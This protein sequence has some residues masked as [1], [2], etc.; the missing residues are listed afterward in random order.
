[1]ISFVIRQARPEDRARIT[2]LLD[3]ASLPTGGLTEHLGTFLVAERNQ[4]I[5]G[6]IGLE[7]YG[8][9]GLL[10]SAVV[11]AAFR[12]EGIGSSLYSEL[13]VLARTAGMRKLLLLTT[14]AEEYF[15]RKG[16]Q[17]I[18][19]AKVEGPITQS[20]EFR[21]ACPESAVCMELLLL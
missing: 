17:V 19:R 11:D 12:N 15:R 7:S 8:D 2:A 6:A 21:G 9:S 18:D 20:E 3:G 16:F 1:V 14:T 5:L 4:D 13:L 10:R